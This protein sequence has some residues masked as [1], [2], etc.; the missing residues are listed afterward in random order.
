[1]GEGRESINLDNKETSNE[2]NKDTESHQDT[3]ECEDGMKGWDRSI[4]SM[5]LS[6]ES[7]EQQE[8]NNIQAGS[9]SPQK[10]ALIWA[11]E[12]EKEKR[13]EAYQINLEKAEKVVEE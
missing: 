9:I 3:K 10:P 11:D 2:S 7:Q 4:G 6:T 1:M 13:D 5:L 8:G 12:V